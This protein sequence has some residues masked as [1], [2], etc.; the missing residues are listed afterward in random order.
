[1]VNM[2]YDCKF[3]LDIKG[4]ESGVWPYITVELNGKQ[5]YDGLIGKDIAIRFREPLIVG[6]NKLSIALK[7]KSPDIFEQKNLAISIESI[8][9]DNIATDR[10]RWQGVYR[11]FYSAAYIQEQLAKGVVPPKFIP[12]ATFLDWNGVWELEFTCPVFR[13]IHEVENLGWIYD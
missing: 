2:T 8:K 11:P 1:M 9:L 7:N 10:M 6:T 3:E 13:W 5:L 4:Y 12:A